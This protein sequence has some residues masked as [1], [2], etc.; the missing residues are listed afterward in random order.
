[1]ELEGLVAEFIG[2]LKGAKGYSENTIRSYGAD[3]KDYISFVSER[4]GIDPFHKDTLRAYFSGLFKKV[5]RSTISRRLACLRTL[6]SYLEKKGM[7]IQNH[8]KEMPG[9]KK[10]RSL[11]KVML[12]DQVYSLL[13]G[14]MGDTTERLR[15][16]AILETFYSCGLRI[17][18]LV[19]LDLMDVDQVQGLIKVLGKGKKERMVPIGR[20]ALNSIVHYLRATG[21]EAMLGK[22][23]RP[24]FLSRRGTRITPRRVHQIVKTYAKQQGL[25]PE[26][27]PHTFRH[28]FATHLLEG[29][30]DLRSV[31]EL[32]GHSSLST[33]QIYTHLTL[34]KIMDIYDKA[35]PRSRKKEE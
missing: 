2:Y 22:E 10:E 35:H 19:G 24:L 1:V 11:P 12:V 29:G 7:P 25:S 26:V 34:D 14:I 15:D 5:K 8:P 31:Q 30:A 21:R 32:L 18:E 28:T 17:S 27:R 9:I 16:K 13:D 20:T 6:F 23:N 33:T 4:Q 3:L